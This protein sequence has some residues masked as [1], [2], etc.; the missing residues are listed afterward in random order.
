LL[1]LARKA[2]DEVWWRLGRGRGKE[3]E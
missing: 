2:S 3:E 1:S